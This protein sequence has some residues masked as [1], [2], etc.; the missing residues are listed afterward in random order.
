MTLNS[1][2]GVLSGTPTAVGTSTFKVFA[3]NSYAA[4]IKDV[5]VKVIDLD[6]WKY[7]MD[8]TLK[9]TGNGDLSDAT[10]PGQGSVTYSAGNNSYPGT[11]AFDDKGNATQGRWL[12]SKPTSSNPTWIKYDFTQGEKIIEYTVQ[13]QS[14]NFAQRGPKDWTLQGSNDNSNWTTLDTVAGETNWTQW[15]TRTYTPIQSASTVGT[16]WSSPPTTGTTHWGLERLSSRSERAFL[17]SRQT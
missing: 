8:L 6:D 2:T 13:A 5:T 12:A 3:Y 17:V 1:G 11:R 4:A 7:S 16:N 14:Y 10:K 9:Y 15:Q